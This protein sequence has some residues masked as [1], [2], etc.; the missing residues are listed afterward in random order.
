[1]IITIII[2]ITLSDTEFAAAEH[3]VPEY[4]DIFSRAEFDLGHTDMLAH[5]VDT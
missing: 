3:L 4:T 2:I 5:R 1:L